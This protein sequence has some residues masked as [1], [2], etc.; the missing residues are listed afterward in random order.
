MASMQLPVELFQLVAELSSRP[1]QK[2]LLLVSK[3][4][5]DLVLPLLFSRITLIFGIKRKPERHWNHEV[6]WS[7][8]ENTQLRKYNGMATS[9]LQ[10]MAGNSEF[11]K[12]VKQLSIRWYESPL[13]LSS[14]GGLE[15]VTAALNALPS[16]ESFEWRGNLLGLIP[17]HA[18]EALR[19]CPHLRSLLISPMQFLWPEL[20]ELHGLR[21][22]TLMLNVNEW[23]PSLPNMSPHERRCYEASLQLVNSSAP[24]VEEVTTS[25]W[26]F[27]EEPLPNLTAATFLRA[28]GATGLRRLTEHSPSLTSL[29]VTANSWNTDNILSVFASSPEAFHV[30]TSFKF[31]VEYTSEMRDCDADPV[32]AFLKNKRHL[33]RLY[34]GLCSR[35]SQPVIRLL[36]ELPNLEVLGLGWGGMQFSAARAQVFVDCLPRNLGALFINVDE[37]QEALDAFLQLVKQRPALKVCYIPSLGDL[38]LHFIRSALADADSALDLLGTGTELFYAYLAKSKQPQPVAHTLCDPHPDPSLTLADYGL[39][40]W[41]WLAQHRL[42]FGLMSLNV[43]A[44]SVCGTA[45]ACHRLIDC[46]DLRSLEGSCY[47]L[48]WRSFGLH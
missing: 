19:R 43:P 17:R 4:F 48:D 16:L 33:R 37:E 26:M 14:A 25:Y 32:V 9:I 34:L 20:V 1:T 28:T 11:A 3:M 7:E 45:P 12:G 2:T 46:V 41:Q 13:S 40:D 22:I 10:H 30:L 31:L 36:P 18:V 15:A 35:Q 38:A 39:D 27:P 21:K 23:I 29:T 44:C 6:P 42:D 5:H 24:S 47:S 8:E